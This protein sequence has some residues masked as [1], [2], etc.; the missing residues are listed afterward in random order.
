MRTYRQFLALAS[1]ALAAVLGAGPLDAQGVTTG[2]IGGTVR[3][4]EGQLVD[5]AQVQVVN[6][7]TGATTGGITRANGRYLVSG[8]DVGGNYS[9]T[10]RRIGFQP[11]QRDGI[12]V[13]LGQVTTLDFALVRAATVISGVSV[14]ANVADEFVA[15]RT[16]VATTVSDSA[17]RRLP[18]LNRNFTDFVALTPQIATAQNG[19]LSGGGVN[20]RFNSIQIDGA[21]ESDLFGLGA[22]G[23]PGGQ[24]R[25]KSISIEAV[26]EY[27]VLLTPFDVRQGNFA[28]ALI[29]AVTKSGTNDFEAT[30]F[31]YTRDADLARSQPYLTEYSRDQYGFSLGGP[32]V[33]D[34]VHFFVAP[35]WQLEEA[36]SAG[37]YLPASGTA[38]AGFVGNPAVIQDFQD[39]LADLGID[40]GSTELLQKKNPLQNVFGRLDF[41]L[42]WSS[43]L[44]LRH[45]YGYAEDDVFSRTATNSFPLT[46]NAYFFQ[47]TKNASVAQLFTNFANGGYN[48]LQLNYTTI[49]DRRTPR[50]PIPL[51]VVRDQTT[52]N[53]LI[54]AGAERFSMGNELD[55]DIVEVRNDYSQ[56]F[57]NHRVTV[58]GQAQ[59]FDIRN[60]FNRDSYGIWQFASVDDLRAGTPEG[61]SGSTSLGGPIP[62]NMDASQWSFYGQDEWRPTADFS[63]TYGLRMDVPILS[64]KPPHTESVETA[65]GRNTD[66]VPSGNILWSPRVGFNWQVPGASEQQLRGGVG[67]FAGRPAF[68]WLSNAYQNSGSGLGLFTCGREGSTTTTNT[69]PVFDLDAPP[70]AE[71]GN[72]VGPSGNLSLVDLLDEDLN[73]PQ[74]LRATLGYDRRLPWGF[75][76]SIEGLYTRNVNDFFYVNRGLAASAAQD[77]RGRVMYGTVTQ[78]TAGNPTGGARVTVARA[79][80]GFNDVIDVVNTSRNFSWNIT[81]QLRR[82]FSRTFE[83]TAAYTY[84]RVRDVQSPT[85]SQGQSNWRFGRSVGRVNQYEE[86]LGTSLFDVPHKIVVAGTFSFRTKT[87][88]SVIYTGNSGVPFEYVYSSFDANA[89][90]V[91]SNDLIYIP[92]AA[93]NVAARFRDNATLGGTVYTATE[94]AEGLEAFIQG[95][96]CLRGQRGRIMG[97]NSCRSPWQNLVNV[98]LRQR[99]PNISGNE[100]AL[101]LDV[102]NFLNLLNDEWGEQAFAF[103]NAN[104]PLLGVAGVTS[105]DVTTQDPVLTFNPTTERFNA[106]N[107]SSNYQIQLAV[108]YSLF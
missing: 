100:L 88:L 18:T 53:Q 57:G 12:V 32:I 1:L 6:R 61:Y 2:A 29:N 30:A 58:G 4:D 107:S 68:V 10:V 36:P 51:L 44:V 50:S 40:P 83:A 101:Q 93:E 27:Q 47:S 67:M 91:N 3:D 96:E 99:L 52:S 31:Y 85:S 45:N 13:S 25:G 76:G 74:T 80:P 59:F 39:A 79:Q 73:F 95:S 23:Q 90:G 69:V 56:S 70:P 34:R 26:K 16:G 54:L 41:Q 8:L 82:R 89:D 60:L 106:R 11:E 42:P 64:S 28:G 105:N 81:S 103:N 94:Q 22:T 15:T 17:L 97:R 49:R 102:F 35:E 77:K 20:N 98:S 63:L 7:A 71:C 5:A 62:V 87:D 55:Q 48:E 75:V 65:F 9:V 33:K 14:T 108:R 84:S 104:V 86:V 46:S 92:T 19:G 24:A 21:S 38:P 72:G 78:T 43:R 66:D 37:Q